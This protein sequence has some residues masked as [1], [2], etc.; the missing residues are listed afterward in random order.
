MD[1][2]KRKQKPLKVLFGASEVVP[3]SK[4]GGLADVSG[5]LP[6][7]LSELGMEV[8]VITPLY[9]KKTDFEKTKPHSKVKIE[10]GNKKISVDI[11]QANFPGT[12]VTCLLVDYPEYFGRDELYSYPDDAERF[13]LFSKV[14]FAH[15]VSEGNYD[16][17][18]GN[19]W[20]TCPVFYYI[21]AE[22]LSNCYSLLTIHNL[23]YQGVFPKEI[24]EIAGFD[25]SLFY[26][27]GP[28]EFY[29]D[30]SFMKAGIFFADKVNTVSEGYAGEIRTPEYGEG[31]EGVLNEKGVVGILNGV[32]TTIWNPAAD[33]Q[34]TATYNYH[35]L[36]G[37][38]KNKKALQE[39]FKLRVTDAVPL[40]GMISRLADQKGFDILLESFDEI[41]SMPL[42]I[43]LLGTGQQQYHEA[44]AD[45]QKKYKNKFGLFLGFNNSLAHQIEAGSDFFL[46]PS[47]FEPC[48]LNQMYS[49]RYGTVPVVRSTGGLAD[50]IIDIDCNSIAGNGFSFSD[51]S[52][53][54]LVDAIKRAVSR[55]GKKGWEDI[56]VRTMTSDVSLEAQARKYLG[57][58]HC[59]IINSV[60]D[61]AVV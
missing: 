41:M 29:G 44:F 20:Q 4:T 14:I 35:D 22:N 17:F 37:K 51:Y 9:R 25:P 6:L 12:G 32:D 21:K 19:D 3:F 7:A 48:G 42:Q 43:V 56:V 38:K 58:Y 59:M 46:M 26:P 1:Q 18:H 36:S 5:A 11:R 57:L 28:V 52:G 54:A 16:V 31:L 13:T 45:M 53:D 61:N 8:K 15:L 23:Q 27:A 47:R 40:I 24:M 33:T 30:V 10:M 49:L 39:H 50:T 2:I 34:I 55:Y 60:V